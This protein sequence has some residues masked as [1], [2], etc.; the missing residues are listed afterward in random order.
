MTATITPPQG[1][2]YLKRVDPTQ[3]LQ[4]YLNSLEFYL[5]GLG[6]WYDSIVF[7]DNSNSDMQSLK[8]LINKFDANESVELISFDGLDHPASYGK[9]YGEFKLL[10]YGVKNSQLINQ[11]PST[12][13]W[14]V[15]GRYKVLNFGKIVKG[16]SPDLDLYCH[17]RD[18][19]RRWVEMFCFGVSLKAYQLKFI[20]LYQQFREDENLVNPEVVF[21]M[22]IDDWKALGSLR[23]KPRFLV[24]PA[25]SGINAYKNEAYEKGDQK[26]KYLMR[27]TARIFTPWIW[28]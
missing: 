17:C 21:R 12:V 2:P 5:S 22:L 9:A 1:V 25:I 15:T 19:R 16:W 18:F 8:A 10:D 27:E 11:Y 3:R 4:D 14:K 7:V 13:I 28:L 24:T 6:K 23:V 20:G 26:K